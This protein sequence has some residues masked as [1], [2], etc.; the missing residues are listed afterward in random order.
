M[1]EKDQAKKQY[2]VQGQML[3][4]EHPS[5]AL[6]RERFAP[7]TGGTRQISTKRQNL[8]GPLFSSEHTLRAESQW[9]VNFDRARPSGDR[10]MKSNPIRL[11][12]PAQ[13]SASY[14][15]LR[16]CALWTVLQ[17]P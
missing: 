1:C 7:D 9:Q 8:L 12:R 13:N 6:A 16:V 17:K 5:I 4:V 11:S 3:S 2:L 10:N 15:G 14:G